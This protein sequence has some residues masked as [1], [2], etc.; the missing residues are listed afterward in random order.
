MAEL[1]IDGWQFPKSCPEFKTRVCAAGAESITENWVLRK[2]GQSDWPKQSNSDRGE[3][4]QP[5]WRHT[6]F[7]W[8]SCQGNGQPVPFRKVSAV[9]KS[10]TLKW[11]RNSMQTANLDTHTQ[12]HTNAH[13]RQWWGMHS[14]PSTSHRLSHTHYVQITALMRQ[15]HYFTHSYILK[16][17]LVMSCLF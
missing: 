16:R 9:C 11:K 5:H 12:S 15:R 17:S 3:P 14:A 4:S 7:F 8:S 6:P 2:Q 1:R 13:S 10:L